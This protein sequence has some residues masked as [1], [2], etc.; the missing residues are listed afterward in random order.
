MRCRLLVER[1]TG[2]DDGAYPAHTRRRDYVQTVF[3]DLRYSLRQLIRSPGFTLT[4]VISLAL[5]I[6]ATTAVFSVIYAALMNP[7]PFRQADRIMRLTVEDKAGN[8]RS[9]SLSSPQ[10]KE[11]RQS[12]A[13]DSLVAMD[14]GSMTLTGRDLPEDVYAILL[15]PNGFDFLG[16]PAWR[17]RGL[18]P[19]DAI[20]GGSP[21]PVVV[22]GYQ[23]WR[24]HFNSDPTVLGQTLQ[25]QHKNYTIVGIAAPRFRWYSADVYL[26]LDLNQ[27]PVPIFMVNFRP[28]P[29]VSREAVDAAL[30]PVLEQLARETPKHFPE[31]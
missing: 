18:V 21:Q 28:R 1:S 17:G 8:D 13:I 30:Q 16:M 3:Q 19:S 31:H 25:L 11:L 27:D 6:G 2:C 20:E 23:F 14:G 29:G 4:A 10:I 26:P 22:L 5:G 24:R 7:Y 15:T 12:P 9:V